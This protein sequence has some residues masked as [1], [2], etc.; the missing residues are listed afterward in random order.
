MYKPVKDIPDY[1]FNNGVLKMTGKVFPDNAAIFWHPIIKEL[2]NYAKK[3]LPI[4]AVFDF[5][6]YNTASMLYLDLIFRIL[7]G[8]SI[9]ADVQ[10]DWY[11]FHTDEDMEISGIDYKESSKIKKFNVLKK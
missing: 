11:Y 6:Y 4:K 8:I 7:K 10:V 1:S 9:D 2:E 5:D 3:K